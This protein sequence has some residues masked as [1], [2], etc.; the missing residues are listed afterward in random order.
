MEIEKIHKAISSRFSN[1]KYKLY[2]SYVFTWES[3]FFSVTQDNKYIYEVEIKI[4]RSDFFADFKKNEKHRLLS[5]AI[6]NSEKITRRSDS[7]KET[8]YGV[9]TEYSPLSYLNPKESSPNRFYYCC[10]EN[11]ISKEE[12]PDY[13]GLF[14][15]IDKGGDYFDLKEVKKAPLIHRNNNV[16]KKLR[17]LIDKFYFQHEKMRSEYYFAKHQ[18]KNFDKVKSENSRLLSLIDLDK[19]NAWIEEIEY[20]K[21]EIEK[22]KLENRRISA[23]MF[24]LTIENGVLVKENLN[25]Q[26]K[27]ENKQST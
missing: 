15:I 11:M 14:Y 1:H 19:N 13:A 23:K 10:P 20:L 3:D 18:L 17:I 8:T 27:L 9:E 26:R 25:L 6:K 12:L 21:N 16:D 7:I 4:S 22:H 5:S 24:D 2:N